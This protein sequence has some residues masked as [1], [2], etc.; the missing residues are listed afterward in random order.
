MSEDAGLD[1]LP[2]GFREGGRTSNRSAD[3]AEGARGHL[4]G[5]EAGGAQFG[6]ADAYVSALNGN[7]ERQ[8]RGAGKAAEDRDDMSGADHRVAD[9]GEDVDTDTHTQLRTAGD[10]GSDVARSVTDGM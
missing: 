10:S 2:E 6:G 1:Y 9:L 8:A 7:S 5:V 4:R 3:A